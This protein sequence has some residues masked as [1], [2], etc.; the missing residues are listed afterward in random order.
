MFANIMFISRRGSIVVKPRPDPTSTGAQIMIFLL[1]YVREHYFYVREHLYAPFICSR[2]FIC[3][4][5]IHLREH[6]GYVRE[7]L[8]PRTYGRVA[9]S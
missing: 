2:T 4:F 9:C 3:S 6:I 5:Y 1:S 7:H 8:I